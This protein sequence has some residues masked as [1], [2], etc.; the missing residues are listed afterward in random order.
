ML[1]SCRSDGLYY[2]GRHTAL[3]MASDECCLH[4]ACLITGSVVRCPSPTRVKVQF[5]ADHSQETLLS[6]VLLVGGAGPHPVLHVGDFVLCCI[7]DQQGW[8]CTK[9]ALR[10]AYI[11]SQIQVSACTSFTY[12]AS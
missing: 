12:T 3:H 4:H 10:D 2:H 1:A 6:Q 8:H 7:Q 5:A 11:P 9:H